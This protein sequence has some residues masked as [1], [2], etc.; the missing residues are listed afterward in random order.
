MESYRKPIAKDQDEFTEARAEFETL[1][2]Q[3]RS[4]ETESME[5]ADLETF[6]ADRSREVS[7]RLVQAH[8]RRRAAQEPKRESLAGSD[9]VERTHRRDETE[10]G[11]MT[12]FGSVRVERIGYGARGHDSLFPL[13][14]QLNLPPELHSHGLRRYAAEEAARNS[15]DAVVGAVQRGTGTHVP[16]RQVEQLV[17]RAAQD[18]DNFYEDA[19]RQREAT[20][21]RDLL[22][23]S[24]DCKGI[25]MRPEDLTEATR[26]AAERAQP[27]LQMRR[28]PGE[29][30]RKRMAAVGAIYDV[31][32]WQRTPEQ[33][34]GE[35]RPVRVAGARRPRA[36]NKRAW[37]HITK[38]LDEVIAELFD[39][40]ERRDP[41][42]ERT[43]VALVDGDNHQIDRFEAEA[44]RRDVLVVIVVDFM[45]VL[46]YL[47]SAA[48]CFFDKGDRDAETWV[49]E[50]ARLI[51]EGRSSDVAAG[52]RRSATLRGLSD[53]KRETVDASCD[54]FIAKR[55][56]LR[57]DRWLDIGFPIATGVIE[58]ACRYL[59]K[60]RMDI[61]GARWS[62]AGAEAVLRLRALCASGD[63]DAYW[64]FHLS[65][66]HARHH[67][68]RYANPKEV[69]A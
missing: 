3:L 69:A 22:V 14:A 11:L 26:R 30:A 46:E 68:S 19:T 32:P 41:A 21:A 37:A 10:R 50:R 40:A 39:E 58:G 36:R 63:L 65:R 34:L 47:W 8:L 54:Y 61:T 52:V 25:V 62:L 42:H 60:D 45:H 33:I 23:L 59:V 17:E 16:K 2:G 43:W 6:V 35:L 31:E 44:R 55:P 29:K 7:R 20:N 1:V 57:Y 38:S 53:E 24:S 9:G 28:S 13:D 51:L 48:W 18:F 12:R 4:G 66:E 64:R 27:R 49:T 67:S 5:H 15:F 56:Y